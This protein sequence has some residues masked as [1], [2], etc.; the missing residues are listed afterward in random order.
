MSNPLLDLLS[1]RDECLLH[2]M[3]EE[4]Q[5]L[6][7][8]LVCLF[9]IVNTIRWRQSLHKLHLLLDIEHLLNINMLLNMTIY[10]PSKLIVDMML[11]CQ[12]LEYFQVLAAFDILRSD[13]GYQRSHAANVVREDD[14][15]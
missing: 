8:S 10:F 4:H 6:K 12:F 13:V 2:H 15:A 1:Q 5:P 7:H 9:R 14:T 3:T 11:V